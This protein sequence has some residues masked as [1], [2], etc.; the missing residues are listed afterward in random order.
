MPEAYLYDMATLPHQVKGDFR[1]LFPRTVPA[2][3]VSE[4]RESGDWL[5]KLGG[6]M[7]GVSF[8]CVG[9]RA[10]QWGVGP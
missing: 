4:E 6:Q 8:N 10:M 2:E 3:E 5:E 9:S 7:V 1:R